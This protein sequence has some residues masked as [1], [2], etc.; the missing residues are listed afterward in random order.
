M[1]KTEDLIG[2]KF[3]K[4][5][6]LDKNEK[7]LTCKC[8][9][10]KIKEILQ[11]SVVNGNTT[12]C[13]CSRVSKFKKDRE[14]EKY[15]KLTAIK[16][17]EPHFSKN[18]IKYI[19]YLF[20]CECG[21]TKEYVYKEVKKGNIK[22]CGCINEAKKIIVT[23]GDIYNKFTILSEVA[24]DIYENGAK[25]RKILVKC[26]CGTEK[27]IALQSVVRGIT[28]DCGCV[29]KQKAIEL[30]DLKKLNTPENSLPKDTEEE[31]WLNFTPYHLVSTLG[32][33]YAIKRRDYLNTFKCSLELVVNGKRES[34]NV[35]NLVY[36]TFVE[37]FDKSEYAIVARDG[38]TRNNALFNLFLA[39]KTKNKSV[40]MYKL[41]G[42]IN[43]SARLQK[44]K[45]RKKEIDLKAKDLIEIYERQNGK[46][47]FLNL[48]MDMTLSDNLLS[49][50]VDRIDND[51]DYTKDNIT[52]VTRFENM[53]RRSATFEEM[54][55]FSKM[56]T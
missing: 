32:R 47:V 49:A 35:Q 48:P 1:Y 28:K 12:S 43:A 40:W 51:K 41:L 22:S 30:K 56:L 42:N 52:L 16:E 13:G 4:L 14:G 46:S 44:G 8:E 24:P 15:N 50:S 10:G 17:T 45:Q 31:K 3:N 20:K 6:I 39:H 7:Y 19:Q 2:K 54:E 25:S 11:A 5:I 55:I 53:G 18:G 34:Y 21:N 27:E 23:S 26:E 36:E 9:C 29:G 33:I 38:N 37:K